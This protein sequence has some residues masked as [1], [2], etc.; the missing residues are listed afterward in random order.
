MRVALPK[1]SRDTLAST[2]VVIP[3][4]DE[5]QSIVTFLDLETAKIDADRDESTGSGEL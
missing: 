3:P 2:P 1:V 5:Q 4:R